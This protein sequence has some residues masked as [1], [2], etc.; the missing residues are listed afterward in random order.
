MICNLHTHTVYCDGADTPLEL[1]RAAAEKGFVSLG[2]TG[3][4]YTAFDNFGMDEARERQY[5]SAVLSARQE[6]AGRLEVVLGIEQDW[7]TGKA[8]EG[9][10]L[11]I[12]SV[13]SLE[14]DGKYYCLDNTPE[15]LQKA[16]A[17]FGGA[18]SLCEAYFGAVGQIHEKTGCGIVGHLDLITKFSEKLRLPDTG[19]EWYRAAWRGAL[20]RLGG[21]ELIFEVNTG[22]MARGWRTAPYPSA[23][24][25]REIARR[26]GLVTVTSDCHSRD[27]LD[28]GYETALE[29]LRSCGFRSHLI[30]AGGGFEKCPL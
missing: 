24:I 12:G 21:R 25:L 8:P 6:F 1:C 30:W 19:A 27:R 11:V 16:A 5:R 28:F 15:E 3:H 10:D 4:S 13:H 26:R 9:Y 14:R 18:R 29:L 23:E 2:F 22:A 7:L 20:D 17:A